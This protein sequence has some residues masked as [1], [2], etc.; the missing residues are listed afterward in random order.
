VA[1]AEKTQADQP[2]HEVRIR[3]VTKTQEKM[4]AEKNIA[5]SGGEQGIMSNTEKHYRARLVGKPMVRS[6]FE[7]KCYFGLN[8]LFGRSEICEIGRLVNA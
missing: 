1:I 4:S 6:G 8:C 2:D 3:Q 7:P 5:L